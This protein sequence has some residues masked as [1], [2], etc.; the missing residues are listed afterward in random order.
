MKA[1]ILA[2]GVGSRIMPLTK[3]IPKCLIKINNKTI[4]EMM[5]E[6]CISTGIDDFIFVLGHKKHKVIETIKKLNYDIKYSIVENKEYLN[7]NTGVS[8]YLAITNTDDTVIVINGDN[9]FDKKM[10]NTLVKKDK[11]SIV[12]DNVKE[13]NEESFKIAIT[14]DKIEAIGK[15]ILKEESSGEFIGIS[16]IRKNDLSLF[17]EILKKIID[18]NKNQYYDFA[19]KEL[20]KFRVVDFVY[21]NGLIWSEI[22]YPEDLKHVKKIIFKI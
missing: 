21:T 9:V 15:N 11:T 2:A 5:I 18:E 22:D 19:F 10:L 12:V 6:N 13:L 16:M 4:L 20:S 8:L 17:M 7:T 14:N 3:N 1:I